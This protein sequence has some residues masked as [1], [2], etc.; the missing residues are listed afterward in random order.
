MKRY[1]EIDSLVT[2]PDEEEV[3]SF[4]RAKLYDWALLMLFCV[5]V[6]VVV[7]VNIE[8]LGV[9]KPGSSIPSWLR[10]IALLPLLVLLEILRRHFNQKVILKSNVIELHQGRLAFSYSVPVLDYVDI[11]EIRI[12]Q[13]IFERLLDFGEVSVST[14][15][16]DIR[17]MCIV[18]VPSPH[19]FKLVVERLRTLREHAS[20]A[21]RVNR[22]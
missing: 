4:H 10:L 1:P 22:D 12:D 20:D 2:L 8:V 11:R 19:K 15:G 9:E 17:E 21:E 13:N 16:S 3:L 14:A 5:L 6:V 7:Y 18:G